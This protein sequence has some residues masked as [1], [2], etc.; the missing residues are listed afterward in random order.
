MSLEEE[1]RKP[2]P[3][4]QQ[5]RK[6]EKKDSHRWK[7]QQEE[8]ADEKKGNAQGQGVERRGSHFSCW[9][10]FLCNS[11]LG[12]ALQEADCVISQ[13]VAPLGSGCV[14]QTGELPG[15]VLDLLLEFPTVLFF[16]F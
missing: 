3:E 5:H 7:E 13:F 16:F 6:S 11:G 14:N 10:W 12:F 1:N 2:S 8:S 15:Q 9:G 4:R